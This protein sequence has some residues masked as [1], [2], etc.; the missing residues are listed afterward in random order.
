MA[1]KKIKLPIMTVKHAGVVKQVVIKQ[2]KNRKI[3]G[4]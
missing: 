4:G 3:K 2:D 1:K